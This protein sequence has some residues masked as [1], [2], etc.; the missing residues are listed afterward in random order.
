MNSKAVPS[1]WRA[2][3]LN[4][5]QIT[6]HSLFNAGQTLSEL[7]LSS[8]GRA[9]PN[10][11]NSTE[12]RLHLNT[13]LIPSKVGYTSDPRSPREVNS[14]SRLTFLISLIQLLYDGVEPPKLETKQYKSVFT[15]RQHS[16]FCSLVGMYV[17]RGQEVVVLFFC[18]PQVALVKVRLRVTEYQLNL[19]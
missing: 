6:E 12:T 13:L 17:P 11:Q 1:K 18:L 14:S 7:E 8:R 5:H 19:S 10:P 3:L 15:A 4:M 16:N 2:H 9:D